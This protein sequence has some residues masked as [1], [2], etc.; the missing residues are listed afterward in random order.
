MRRSRRVDG[1]L[2]GL[3]AGMG[4]R[5]TA[6][7]STSAGVISAIAGG[8]LGGGVETWI[9][10]NRV[11]VNTAVTKIVMGRHGLSLVSFSEHG[12][13]APEGVTYR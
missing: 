2:H 13:L 8:L 12:H 1:A 9:R 5:G 11:C 3:A 7:V 10:L 6:V 4:P